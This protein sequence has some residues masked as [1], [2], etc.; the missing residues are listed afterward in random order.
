M[1]ATIIL[2]FILLAGM[3]PSRYLFEISKYLEIYN[4]ATS[5][6]IASYVDSITPEKI[7]K[8]ALNAMLNALDPYTTFYEE[9]ELEE[10]KF[11]TT[12]EYGGIGAVIGKDTSSKYVYIIDLYDEGPAKK[13]GL[14]RGDFITEISEKSTQNLSVEEA[15]SLLRG[16]PG[17]KVSIKVKRIFP[18]DSVFSLTLTRQ[19]IKVPDIPFTSLLNDSTGYLKLNSFTEGIAA[20]VRKKFDSLKKEGA[21]SFILDLRGNGGGLLNEAIS[22][23]S[24]FLPEGKICV[25]TSG[26]NQEWS[27][28]YYTIASSND[29]SIPLAVLIDENSASA[30]EIVAGAIQDYDRGVIIG[31]PSFG[32]GLIQQTRDL[33]YDTKLK[34]TVARY[35]TP[36]GRCIQKIDYSRRDDSNNPVYYPDSLHKIFYTKNNR[37]VKSFEGII[38]DVPVK[39]TINSSILT[40]QFYSKFIFWFCVYYYNTH[41]SDSSIL[42]DN[43]KL[44]NEFTNYL[45]KNQWTDT[46]ILPLEESLKQI[47]T[48]SP[49]KDS[50]LLAD[51]KPDINQIKRKINEYKENELNKTRKEVIQVV[52]QRLLSFYKSTSSSYRYYVE[53]DTVVRTAISILSDHEKYKSILCPS[54]KIK[55]N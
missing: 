11:L 21:K 8:T 15:S 53:N 43:Q 2:G 28:N 45:K 19:E 36:S 7:I 27:R 17:T 5:Q 49:V 3:S 16:V 20:E 38:P 40:S 50:T 23:C 35:H 48:P 4:E 44:W 1:I 55:N 39:D 14:R 34:I 47:E 54:I 22:I 42:D 6:I 24:I 18:A 10:Y 9:K 12:G 52:K 32:K 33:P 26:R 51:I 25:K 41:P 29:T 30:S 13:N 31:S 46:P 37:P